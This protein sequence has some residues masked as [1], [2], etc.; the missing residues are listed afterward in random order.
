MGIAKLVRE[1]AALVI[2]ILLPVAVVVFFLLA[3]MIPPL[4]VGPPE[5]SFLFA[6]D[7]SYSG[8]QSRW[9][10]QI[11]VDSGRKL[12]VRAFPTEPATYAPHARLFLY[13][14]ASEQVREIKLPLPETRED[15]A[16]GVAVEVPEF[17]DEVIDPNWAAPD[18]YEFVKPDRGG[19]GLMRLFYPRSRRGLSISKSG[20]VVTVPPGEHL[21]GYQARF[22]GWIVTPSDH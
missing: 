8:P 3:T 22:V 12:R 1:N 13:E 10:Y 20:A 17:A 2:G 14:P 5:Y 21:Y 9:R 15:A 16:D 19:G 11:D 4:L 18:G 7:Y 6:Q